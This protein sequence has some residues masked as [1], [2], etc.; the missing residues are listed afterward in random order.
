MTERKTFYLHVLVH[1]TCNYHWKFMLLCISCL[2]ISIFFF[3][4]Y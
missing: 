3:D 2:Y 4:P 1:S